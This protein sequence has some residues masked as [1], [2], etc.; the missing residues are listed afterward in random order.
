LKTLL[1]TGQPV[2]GWLYPRDEE[3]VIVER[4]SL[5]LELASTKADPSDKEE[6]AEALFYYELL[7]D[8][9]LLDAHHDHYGY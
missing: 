5:I 6:W 7:S 9:E 2:E 3:V 1:L 8:L 4:Q